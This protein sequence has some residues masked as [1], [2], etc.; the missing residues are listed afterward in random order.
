MLLN[1]FS[2]TSVLDNYSQRAVESCS[3]VPKFV[4]GEI[5]RRIRSV[6]QVIV[7]ILCFTYF[8]LNQTCFGLY[9]YAAVKSLK[10]ENELVAWITTHTALP[11]AVCKSPEG[12]CLILHYC[13]LISFPLFHSY[14]PLTGLT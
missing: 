8:C 1:V 13:F 2:S 12:T 3:N 5:S 10:K 7:K 11:C 4:K 14:N 6:I 9:E